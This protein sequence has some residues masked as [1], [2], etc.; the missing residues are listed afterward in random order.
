MSCS[1]HHPNFSRKPRMSV[2]QVWK[3]KTS[4]QKPSSSFQSESPP[5]PPQTHHQSISPP[6]Y[7]PLRDEMKIMFAHL[8]YLLTTAITSHFPPPP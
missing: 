2:R 5:L 3:R 7:N 6:S 1:N 8:E 4:T